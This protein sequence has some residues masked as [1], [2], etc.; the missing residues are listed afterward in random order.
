VKHVAAA[1]VT[2]KEDD[3]GPRASQ[4]HRLEFAPLT[5]EVLTVRDPLALDFQKIGIRC[6]GFK[7]FPPLC[8]EGRA[9]FAVGHRVVGGSTR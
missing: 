8:F 5:H 2:H 3:V 6:V 1:L 9:G 4:F 7:C